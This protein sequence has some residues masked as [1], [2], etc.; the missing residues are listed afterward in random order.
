[1]PWSVLLS[2]PLFV[3]AVLALSRFLTPA[4]GSHLAQESPST[5]ASLS[6]ADKVDASLKAEVSS[7]S[8]SS[9]QTSDGLI[10]HLAPESEA[11]FAPQNDLNQYAKLRSAVQDRRSSPLRGLNTVIPLNTKDIQY[12]PDFAHIMHQIERVW[13]YPSALSPVEGIGSFYF[14]TCYRERAGEDG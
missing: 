13:S 1:M 9:E 11:G 7:E 12:L 3:S 4:G 14:L 10:T 2:V 8:P 5:R 6:Y